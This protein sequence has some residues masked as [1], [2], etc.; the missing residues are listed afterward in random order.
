MLECS[1]LEMCELSCHLDTHTCRRF[2]W[3]YTTDPQGAKYFFNTYFWIWKRSKW[4]WLLPIGDRKVSCW[5]SLKTQGTYIANTLLQKRCYFEL[6]DV[7]DLVGGLGLPFGLTFQKVYLLLEGCWRCL[8][9]TSL[10][11]AVS[12]L[13]TVIPLYVCQCLCLSVKH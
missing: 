2:K 7:Y 6:L 8:E 5:V 12:E 3:I 4:I 10:S 1:Y 9:C 11:S 13:S